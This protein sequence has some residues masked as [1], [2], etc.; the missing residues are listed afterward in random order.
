MQCVKGWAITDA[1]RCAIGIHSCTPEGIVPRPTSN[2]AAS[3]HECSITGWIDHDTGIDGI[4]RCLRQA[5]RK[6]NAIAQ[7]IPV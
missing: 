3:G 6:G 2:I 4:H 7:S 5:H 1:L